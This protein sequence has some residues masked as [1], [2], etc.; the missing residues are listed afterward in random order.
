MPFVTP[1]TFT[2]GNILTATQLNTLS[3]NQEYLYGIAT[4]TNVPFYGHSFGVNNESSEIWYWSIRHKYETFLYDVRVDLGTI[5]QVQIKMGGIAIFTD[6]TDHN[7]PYTYSGTIDLTS[8]GF[9]VGTWYTLSVE[10]WGSTG[11][12][13]ARVWDMR[14][15][16]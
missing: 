9:T 7:N 13:H 4:Q 6:A 10:I 1:P 5:S 12:N 15:V 2:D 11:N 8:H 3:D 16:R 14:E